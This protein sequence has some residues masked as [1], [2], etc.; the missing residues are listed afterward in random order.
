MR[1]HKK[2]KPIRRR[3]I[4]VRTKKS[5]L[6]RKGK[7]KR[8]VARRRKIQ[9]SV[10]D[11]RI[12]TPRGT[13]LGTLYIPKKHNLRDTPVVVFLP[14]RMDD[15]RQIWYNNFYRALNGKGIAAL[16]LSL[17]GHGK[18]YGAFK[19]FTYSRGV[20]DAQD[21]IRW[22]KKK[23]VRRIG[24]AGFSQGGGVTLQVVAQDPTLLATV[25]V[26][27]VVFPKQVH[28]SLLSYDEREFLKTHSYVDEEATP[29]NKRRVSR[30]FFT[31]NQKHPSFLQDAEQIHGPVL[32]IHGTK[33]E[34]VPLYHSKRFYQELGSEASLKALHTIFGTVHDFSNKKH[35][36]ELIR[37]VA[38]FFTLRLGQKVLTS[39]KVAVTHQGKVLLLKRST[40]VYTAHLQWDVIGGGLDS[41]EIP[42][43]KA[44]EETEEE[45]GIPRAYL[46]IRKKA[47]WLRVDPGDPLRRRK[48]IYHVESDTARVKLNW[49]NVDAMWV[50]PK[51]LPKKN[52]RKHI[53]EYLRRVDLL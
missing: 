18:S 11:V 6:K 17:N 7:V 10:T 40:R 22:L 2:K 19:D 1:K 23:G 8:V 29:G 52:L 37:A 20:K 3:G 9:K 24:M 34:I 39:V 12:R 51:K 25:L 21:A 35:E 49:E 45:S 42:D 13:L 32:I 15:H 16:G 47:Y 33:D 50:D 28:E 30:S 5:I 31:E 26:A 14:G 53:R 48:Y 36:H 38:D 46:A 41:H 44:L 4:V 27:P 43:K